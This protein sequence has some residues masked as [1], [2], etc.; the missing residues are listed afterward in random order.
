M[1]DQL[2]RKLAAILYADV[3]G[4][5]GAM[6]IGINSEFISK[7]QLESF[8][9]TYFISYPIY[10]SQPEQKSELGLIPGLPT[11][12]LVSPEGSVVARQIGPVTRKMI[13]RFIQKREA[14]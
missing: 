8:L 9:D 11:T 1:A 4:D 10:T 2:P 13:E 7:Q 12:F 6:V 14:Q 3:A 5:K